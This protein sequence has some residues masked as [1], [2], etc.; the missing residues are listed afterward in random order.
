MISDIGIK[1]LFFFCFF[2]SFSEGVFSFKTGLNNL[3]FIILILLF[4]SNKYN[5][6]ISIKSIFIIGLLFKYQPISI[7]L[8]KLLF[9]R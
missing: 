9:I 8:F 1:N 7:I 5:N 3:V 6:E 2:S 4:L